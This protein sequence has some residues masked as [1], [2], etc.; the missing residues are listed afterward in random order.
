M[1]TIEAVTDWSIF[2]TQHSMSDLETNL[3]DACQDGHLREFDRT[4][5]LNL[6]GEELLNVTH[7]ACVDRANIGTYHT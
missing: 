3:D 5:D 1:H 2:D 7:Q 6:L 4:E